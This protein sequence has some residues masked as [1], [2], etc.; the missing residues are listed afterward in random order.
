M[1][2]YLVGPPGAGK[3]HLGGLLAKAL[4]LPF[5]DLDELIELRTGRRVSQIFAHEGEAGFRSREAEALAGLEGPVVIATGGGAVV[6]P[7]NRQLLKNGRT[8]YLR[9]EPAELLRRIGEGS[10][11][12]LLAGRPEQILELWAEREV[13]YREV[14]EAVVDT[15]AGEPVV[16]ANRLAGY[17]RATDLGLG[18]RLGRGL[19]D[20][21]GLLPGAPRKIF[22]ISDT[23]VYELYGE[24]AVASLEAAG[25]RVSV[26][27][28]NPGEASKN[29][30]EAERLYH[31]GLQGGIDRSGAVVALGGGVVGDLA[32]FVS[33]T[34]L[35]GLDLYQVPTTLLAQVDAAIGGK[36]GVDLAEGKN[37]VGAFHL[38]R[39]VLLDP[40]LLETLEPRDWREGLAE[41]V[42]Y[43]LLGDAELFTA[44]GAG[45]PE[46]A[47]MVARSAALKV[48][49]VRSDFL[50]ESGERALLNLGHTVG[51]AVEAVTGYGW[52]HGTAVAVGLLAASRLSERLG[53]LPEGSA[54]VEEVLRGLG[55]PIRLPPVGWRELRAA[56]GFDKKIADGRLRFVLL[57]RLGEAFLTEVTDEEALRAV[58]LELGA[59]S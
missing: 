18:V 55:L 6:W 46:P 48:A 28:I 49:V 24:L 10:G 41:V 38:P 16:L 35:R 15:T 19:L 23:R 44:L 4:D 21:V 1:R 32:G 27:T 13:W 54:Q 47:W 29:L 52:S 51:H 50:E 7:E 30:G 20:T 37:L 25:H 40:D 11:R 5:V 22:L 2:V 57:R 33:A 9:A 8:I 17:L 36:V 31:L 58:L 53:F 43:G 26:A 34:L 12:P 3:S 42:K 39:A 45:R 56:M 14:S 59:T